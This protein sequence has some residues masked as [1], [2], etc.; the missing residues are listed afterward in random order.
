MLE[1]QVCKRCVLSHSFPRIEF[2]EDG[3][4]SVCRDYDNWT[5]GWESKLPEQRKILNRI[6]KKVKGQNKEFDA[7]IPF[8][9]G[10][11]SSYVLYIA[12]R[13][14]GLNCLAYTFDNGYLSMHARNNIDRTC[15][16]LGENICIIV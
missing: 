1:S 4:C 9:G 13:E 16:K 3:V 15:R 2:D 14:L 5:N 10:K 7:L 8:S 11:D 12:K 6:C